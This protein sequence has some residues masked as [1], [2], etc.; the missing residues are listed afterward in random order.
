MEA[1]GEK[2]AS[3]RPRVGVPAR[4][5]DDG[6][7]VEGRS[8]RLF[9]ANDDNDALKQFTGERVIEDST[10]DRWSK[11]LQG[12][13]ERLR[14]LE[15]DYF[16]LVPPDSHAVYPDELPEGVTSAPERTIDLFVRRME[17]EHVP[18]PIIYPLERLRAE[19]R[20]GRRG[21]AETDSHWNDFGA[22]VAYECLM[23]QVERV[24]PVR[25]IARSEVVF[26]QSIAT[27]DLGYKLDPVRNS[28]YTWALVRNASARL[29]YDNQVENRGGFVVT[30]CPAAPPVT[31][32]LF[33]D[34]F[35]YHMLKFLSE[36]F[37]KLILAHTP[38]V[39]FDLVERE[40]PAVVL[41]MVVE[42]HLVWVPDDE[43]GETLE[44]FE[45]RK[46]AAGR[47]RERL[48]GWD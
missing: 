6:K 16:F 30:E 9:L 18:V 36:S 21:Y 19:E 23:D 29:I 17:R 12:R 13:Y 26:Q 33:G 5:V 2:G 24:T 42:R 32:V 34:S 15:A 48:P 44:D 1:G 35:S 14:G 46:V 20:E 45:R 3:D 8:G 22:F 4:Y 31:C 43:D 11:L 27:G 38:R 41:T 47:V 7:V 10:L 37:R 28:E 39:D 25:R 40:R